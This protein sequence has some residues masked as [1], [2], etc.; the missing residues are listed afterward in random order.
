MKV[1]SGIQPTGQLHIG[2]YLG[3]VKYWALLQEKHDCY[4][5][6]VDLHA[7]TVQQKSEEFSKIVLQKVVELISVGIDPERCVLFLQSHVKE[8]TELAWIFNTL[9]PIAE[10]ERMTQFKD[11]SAKNTKNINAGLLTYPALMAA[12]ILLYKTDGVPVGKDQ[13]Q[14]LELTRMV[15]KKFNNQYGK[16]FEEPDS[17]VPKEG[18]RIMSL[19]DPEKK[20][21]KSDASSSYIS[22]FETPEDIKKK[23]MKATTDTEDAIRYSPAEKPGVSNLLSIYSLFAQE[24]PEDIERKFQGKGYSHLKAETAELLADKLEPFRRKKKELDN[25]EI[26]IKEI[27][28]RGARKA[29]LA[30]SSTMEEVRSKVGLVPLS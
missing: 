28:K 25:R 2:N 6:V 15:A 29:S 27:L 3:A 20:M 5:S 24:S 12:D 16:T 21:S 17:L 9:I 30:A 7:L 22:L 10:L 8:H 11:K 23:I 4:F 13:E 26:Y 1:F 14:H 19:Q 18:A